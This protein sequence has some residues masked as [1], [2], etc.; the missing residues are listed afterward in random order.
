LK[1]A[2]LLLNESLR[3]LY[4]DVTEADVAAKGRLGQAVEK[5]HFGYDPNSTP[6]PDFPHAGVELK[7]TPLKE[8]SDHSLLSK[9]RLVLNIIN[10]ETA[11]GE[12]FETSSFWQKNKYLLLMFYLHQYAAE[13][14]PPVS[15]LDFLFKIIRYWDFPATDLQIIRNDWEKIHEKIESGRAHEISEGDTLYLGACTKGSRGGANKRTQYRGQKPDADQRAYS[16]KSSYLNRIILDSIYHNIG[17]GNVFISDE[18]QKKWLKRYEKDNAELGQILKSARTL[19]AG[20]TFEQYIER[21]FKPYY[22]NTIQQIEKKCRETVT[23]GKGMAYDICRVILG[24]KNKRI[25]EFEKAGLQLKTIRLEHNGN[26]KEAMSFPNIDFNGII[27]EEWEDSS[28]YNILTNR[29]L[30]VVFQKQAGMQDDKSVILK[31]VFFWTM[32][33]EDLDRAES[34][35][36]DTKSKIEAGDYNHFIKA[37]EHPIC[38]VRPKAQK[39]TDTVMTKDGLR[40]RNAIGSTELIFIR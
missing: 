19:R 26:L 22:G 38:H 25:A 33:V 20:E 10:Y 30:F 6:E 3:S 37:S 36:Y 39:K 15:Y 17:C 21:K 23:R 35:W 11:G 2:R 32:P 5:V 18:Q 34:F 40:K 24:V 7:C 8:E 12:Q 31:K 4:P 27:H 28:W 16:L 1:H 9:E 13:G 29:F 14:E